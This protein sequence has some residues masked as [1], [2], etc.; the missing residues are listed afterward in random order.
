MIFTWLDLNTT[1]F[2]LLVLLVTGYALLDG[3]DLGIGALHLFVSDNNGRQTMLRAIGP[4]W[5]GNE[6]WLITAGGALFA[7]FP[8]AYA[9][10]FS[11]FYFAMVLVLL[12]LIIRAIAIEVRN[13]RN[14][15]H[16]R[17]FWDV[18]FS[19]SSVLTALLFGV[20]LGNLIRGI[21]LSNTHEF[22]GSFSILLN[23]FALLVG[24]TTVFIFAA[25]GAAFGMLKTEGA[26]HNYL[27]KLGIITGFIS[28]VTTGA[29]TVYAIVN[30]PHVNAR[31]RSAPW[32]VL[33]LAFTFLCIGN[34][35]RKFVGN[36]PK[37][38]FYSS[39]GAII[40]L[41]AQVAVGLYPN[42]VISYPEQANS[43]TIYNA[44]SS[45]RTLGIML[46][47]ALMGLPLVV[48]YTTVV[49]RI[50]KGKIQASDSGY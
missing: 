15:L 3:F 39:C 11:G 6:V 5:D 33:L 27:R 1:W 16:W 48:V 14:T 29:V 36:V 37:H 25:H 13:M 4:V 22:T 49:Y 24:F 41:L 42:L 2:V 28:L 34:M 18:C 43:L 19:L 21:P 30:L 31:V 23:P 9:T 17:R 26:L 32:L 50:F 8:T 7:A 20:A 10:V 38:A 12:S 35:V 44:A 45:Q 46:V 40:T 47:V